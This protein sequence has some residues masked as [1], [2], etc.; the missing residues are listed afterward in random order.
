MNHFNPT[1]GRPYTWLGVCTILVAMGAMP[2][3]AETHKN[4]AGSKV[5]Q[6][7]TNWDAVS[8]VVSCDCGGAPVSAADPC[9]CDCDM[10]CP[11]E[12]PCEDSCCCPL[13]TIRA[14]AIFLRRSQTSSESL[15]FA[16]DVN[17][18]G[19]QI[20]N[21]R[22]FDDDDA[23]GP[24][25]WVLRCLNECHSL[26][27]RFF[28]VDSWSTSGTRSGDPIWI[29][30]PGF[31]VPGSGTATFL[32]G[33]DLY[34]AELNLKRRTS[35]W[36]SL[37]AGFRWVEYNEDL[38]LLGTPPGGP[39]FNLYS[40]DTNNHLYGFQLGAESNI[41]T[42]N[43]LWRFDA[44]A[45]AGVY[46]NNADQTTSVIGFGNV[47]AKTSHTAFIGDVG[48]AVVRQ[49]TSNLALRAGYQLLWLEG[50]ALAPD[51]L[52]TTDITIPFATVDTSGSPFFH[53]ALL[54]LEA[55]W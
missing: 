48:V 25:I 31:T 44:W 15:I 50:V 46:Y 35:D 17:K 45:K 19:V 54:G 16:D 22:D 6:T 21:V 14:G 33:S 51:Q 37:L 13:W 5:I 20:L 52:A 11:C 30:F 40:I 7:S 32:Y 23:I 36:L 8:P 12:V 41:W 47:N 9:P 34:S 28:A 4:F 49:L 42:G 43:G 39:T 26:E 53:G 29:V 10:E 27:F 3:L 38:T 24:D 2:V 18:P 1:Q 55:T